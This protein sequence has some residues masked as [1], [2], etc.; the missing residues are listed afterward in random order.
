[1]LSKA[2]Q[3][4]SDPQR[5]QIY[6]QT[7]S[8][9][10]SRSGGG[11]NPF[12]GFA[13]ASNRGPEIS[14]DDFIN[15]FFSPGGGIFGNG[16]GIFDDGR[17]FAFGGPGIRVH[18]FGGAGPRARRRHP[19]PQQQQH[20]QRAGAGP[21]NGDEEDGMNLTR[22]FWQLLPLILFFLLPALSGLL[23]GGDGDGRLRGPQFAMD[24]AP[25]YTQMRVT[26][27]FK[28]P[29]YVNPKDIDGL[30]ARDVTSLGQ[31]AEAA[32][33]NSYSASCQREQMAQ[34]QVLQDAQGFFFTDHDMVKK[35]RDMPLPN[36]RKL[37]QLGLPRRR[38]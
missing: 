2:F 15:M 20:Q 32:I 8:D 37:D 21:A 16:G 5:R 29:F 33:V 38:Y 7:G 9:S 19:H 30:A 3:V 11:G 13:G 23:G 25:P 6:D 10:D 24:P 31:R 26:P 34:Q 36:C 12:A 28:I 4:L 22:M 17:G 1:M 18:Q 35:A 27:Q 14:P